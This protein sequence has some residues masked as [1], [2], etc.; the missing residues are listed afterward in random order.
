[1]M[2]KD[3]INLPSGYEIEQAEKRNLEGAQLQMSIAVLEFAG[4]GN[5]WAR[6]QTIDQ[7]SEPQAQVFFAWIKSKRPAVARALSA[8]AEVA[9]ALDTLKK[10]AGDQA[11]I[12]RLKQRLDKIT[13]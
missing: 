4:E 9:R 2:P 3:Q 8:C 7:W 10:Q 12:A 13:K 11:E 6:Q 1:M 5:D